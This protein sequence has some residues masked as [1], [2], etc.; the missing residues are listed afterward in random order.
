M[1]QR[2]AVDRGYANGGSPLVMGL[3]NVLV[4]QTIVTQSV[5]RVGQI[6]LYTTCIYII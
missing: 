1:L 4:E 2:V 3:V 5:S 6:M